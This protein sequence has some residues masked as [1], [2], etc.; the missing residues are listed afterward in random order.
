MSRCLGVSGCLNTGELP[1]LSYKGEMKSAMFRGIV[2]Y[3]KAVLGSAWILT[4]LVSPL[5]FQT[6]HFKTYIP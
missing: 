2:V 5:G 6:S 1:Q 4:D 3:R